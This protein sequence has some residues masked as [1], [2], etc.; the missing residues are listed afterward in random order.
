M[1]DK[2]TILVADDHPLVRK[3]LVD[4]IREES[5]FSVVADVGDGETALKII[6][7]NDITL[8]LLDLDMPKMNGLEVVRNTNASNRITEFII[9]TMHKDENIFD[10]AMELG[11][12]GFVLKESALLDVVTCLKTV[13]KGE[14]YISPA[15][16]TYMM[17]NR[18]VQ[19]TN[20]SGTHGIGRL[21]QTERK[22]LKLVAE[23]KSSQEIADALF[24]SIRT[25]GN[26]RNNICNKLD[27]HGANALLKYAIEHKTML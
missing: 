26:H 9:V 27:V 24:V 23:M 4:I 20:A 3:G 18:K 15:L 21:T 25:I 11:V 6:K 10:E 16:S 13:L 5:D 14:Y 19:E 8:A 17:K 7:E 12:M 22:I 2:T 1:S